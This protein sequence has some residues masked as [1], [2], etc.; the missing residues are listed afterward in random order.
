MKTEEVNEKSSIALL[1]YAI[2]Y[3]VVQLLILQ[4]FNKNTNNGVGILILFYY[5]PVFWL[6]CFCFLIFLFIVLKIKLY[7]VLDVFSLLFSTPF[8]MIVYIMSLFG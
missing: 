5:L 3:T 8:P 2:V 6:F 7:T 4:N 1:V